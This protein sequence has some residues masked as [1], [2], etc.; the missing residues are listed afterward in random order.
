MRVGSLCSGIGGLELA[1]GGDLRWAAETAPA[2]STVLAR[3]FPSAVNH[4]DWTDPAVWDDLE[5]VDL[6][7]GGLPCQPISVAGKQEGTEDDRWLY[8]DLHRLLGHLADR[9]EYPMLFLEN[10]SAIRTLDGGSALR[11][12]VRGLATLGWVGRYGSLRA[13]D[14]GAPHQRERGFCGARHPNGPRPGP[15]AAGSG[16]RGPAGESGRVA[17]DPTSEGRQRRPRQLGLV[18]PRPGRVAADP[19]SFGREVVGGSGVQPG[20]CGPDGRDR[21]RFGG[22][23]PAIRRWERILG[24]P[25]PDPTG[26]TRVGKEGLSPRFVE[27]MMGYPD[28]WA[29]DIEPRRNPCLRL[30]GNAVV[31]QQ[32]AAAWGILFPTLG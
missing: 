25:A 31:P 15:L 3:R 7:V 28:G 9:G 11:R 2:P 24:R 1:V 29:T 19:D 32:A 16:P 6:I 10:V 26:P 30:L 5:P 20:E 27:W 12:T 8:D 21:S 14:I 17:G 22:Y 13:S 18:S 23:A 4:G